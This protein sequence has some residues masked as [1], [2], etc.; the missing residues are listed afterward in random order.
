MP[1]MKARRRRQTRRA[2]A[3]DAVFAYVT[4]ADPTQA[5]RLAR[6][7]VEARLAACANILPGMR[8]LYRWQGRIE[9]AREVVLI[10]KTRRSLVPALTARVKQLHSYTVPCVCVLP[11]VGGNADYLRWLMDETAAPARRRR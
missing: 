3:P 8:S 11:I 7:V 6:A 5:E 4:C 2:P 10:L 1:S 9:S